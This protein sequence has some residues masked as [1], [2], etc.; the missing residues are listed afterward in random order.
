MRAYT[1]A[2]AAG[3]LGVD[4]KW[5]DNVLTHHRLGGIHRERQGVSRMIEPRA[6]TVV[7]I[8]IELTRALGAPLVSALRLAE[9]L[10]EEGVHTP[11]SRVSIR[12]DVGD[13][14]REIAARLAD[15]VDI[16]PPRRR[17][18]PPREGP[19]VEGSRP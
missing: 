7:A 2:V 5:L 11:T 16:H 13:I 15:A 4:R 8:A 14:E 10:V 18:R 3:A 9:G 17:G 1:V 6:I 12:V 19:V